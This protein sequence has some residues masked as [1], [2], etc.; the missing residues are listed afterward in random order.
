MPVPTPHLSS[1]GRPYDVWG[2]GVDRYDEVAYR[3]SRLPAFPALDEMRAAYTRRAL[4]MDMADNSPITSSFLWTVKQMA[5][6]SMWRVEG[7]ENDPRTAF[8]QSVLF[9]DL[10]QDW[11]E[12][13]N[14]ALTMLV[15]GWSALEI[16]HKIRRGPMESDRRYRSLYSDGRVGLRMLGYR[17]QASV[18]DW[19]FDAE[20]TLTELTQQIGG[21]TAR[22]DAK[23]LLFFR[24]TSTKP[25]G[26][27]ILRGA[28]AAYFRQ[29]VLEYL[30][31]IGIER[32]LAGFPVINLDFEKGAPDLWAQIA[33]G[34]EEA[35]KA[36][37]T[38]AMLETTVSTVRQDRAMGAV[39]PGW[40]P[41]QLLSA[42]G[43]GGSA[44]HT[45]IKDA[46]H[47]YDLRILQALMA[48]FLQLGTATG[49]GSYGTSESRQSLFMLALDG[50]LSTIARRVNIQLV[51]NL[52][53]LNVMPTEKPPR[54]HVDPLDPKNLSV[55]GSFFQQLANSGL[56]VKA[57]EALR[58]GLSAAI[59]IEIE[60]EPNPKVMATGASNA[61]KGATADP[62]RQ[63][64]PQNPDGG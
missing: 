7:E 54:V 59:G 38:L 22:I 44:R 50:F 60:W 33:A 56:F 63:K 21:V 45:S 5:S 1:R 25:D 10:D 43:G 46:L 4:L 6:R 58:R 12:V 16:V 36:A 30:E 3:S 53:G 39:L 62:Q 14:A 40:A 26:A 52:L 9:E 37:A 27:P 49:G 57:N 31:G 42:G 2:Y 48:D 19:K 24:T 32:D 15:H 51:P 18:W 61:A 8:L 13:L 20:G 23:N 35:A 55:L 34:G 64:G 28:Y 29:Q 47:R 17:P 41:L 11:D